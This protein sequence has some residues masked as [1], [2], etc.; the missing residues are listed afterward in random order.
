M[1]TAS[2]IKLQQYFIQELRDLV[3]ED[4]PQKDKD[5]V[6]DVLGL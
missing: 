1:T 2:T 4:T 6:Y 3:K 5:E